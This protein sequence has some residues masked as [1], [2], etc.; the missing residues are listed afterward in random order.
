MIKKIIFSLIFTFILGIV[1]LGAFNF[2]ELFKGVDFDKLAQDMERAL[3][4]KKTGPGQRPVRRPWG[5]P[6]GSTQKASKPTSTINQTDQEEEKDNKTLFIE[7][8]IISNDTKDQKKESS[9]NDGKIGTYFF[10]RAKRQAYHF[11]MN[12]FID[13]LKEIE[14][15][16]D[17][18]ELFSPE[19]KVVFADFKTNTDE[20]VVAHGIINNHKMY[21][22]VFF[23]PQFAALRKKIVDACE[24]LELLNK[25]IVIDLAQEEATQK[26]EAALRGLA[27]VTLEPL[28]QINLEREETSAGKRR[29]IIEHIMKKPLADDEK[30]TDPRNTAFISGE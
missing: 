7:S 18:S 1:Y 24:R 15:K 9:T 4:E 11:Y 23:L 28:P 10:S 20:I 25:R 22:R 5:N 2:D 3:S 16:I 13:L 27:N 6:F 21:Q 19:F 17:A 26:T 12:H 30:V 8:L 29:G 14:R